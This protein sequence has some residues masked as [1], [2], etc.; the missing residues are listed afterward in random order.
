MRLPEDLP[1]QNP[2]GS[3]RTLETPS[4]FPEDPETPSDSPRL[5]WLLDIPKA[6]R[7][8]GLPGYSCLGGNQ[9]QPGAS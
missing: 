8:T 4:V 3:T 2:G 1:L 9:L 7:P 5:P 6:I